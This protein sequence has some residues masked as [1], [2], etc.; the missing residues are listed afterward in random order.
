MSMQKGNYFVSCD[1]KE[2]GKIK[3]N[4]MLVINHY[5]FVELS[6]DKVFDTMEQLLFHCVKTLEANNYRVD[7]YEQFGVIRVGLTVSTNGYVS[8][9]SITKEEYAKY[10]KY[11]AHLTDK[12]INILQSYDSGY[13]YPLFDGEYSMEFGF[14]L[15]EEAIDFYEKTGIENFVIVDST[16]ALKGEFSADELKLYLETYGT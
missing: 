16:G 9:H 6:K 4:Q 13:L 8:T 11:D 10:P 1:Y 14:A 12:D 7:F 15:I 3:L 5:D 2:D